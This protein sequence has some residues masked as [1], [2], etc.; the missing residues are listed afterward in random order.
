MNSEKIIVKS[1]NIPLSIFD[2]ILTYNELYIFSLFTIIF[3]LFNN[4]F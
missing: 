2:N 1:E 4:Q 3:S